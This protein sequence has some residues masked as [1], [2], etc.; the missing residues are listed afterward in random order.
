MYRSDP[1]S[2][3]NNIEIDIHIVHGDS[4]RAD[5]AGIGVCNCKIDY[6]LVYLLEVRYHVHERFTGMHQTI[7]CSMSRIK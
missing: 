3:G 6:W 1:Y 4:V 5:M 2:M 7:Y